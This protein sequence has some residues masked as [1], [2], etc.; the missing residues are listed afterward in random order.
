MFGRKRK[1]SDDQN[2]SM[3]RSNHT[4]LRKES[5]FTDD[6]IDVSSTAEMMSVLREN[7]Y[8][9]VHAISNGNNT[10]LFVGEKHITIPN[11]REMLATYS[12]QQ[13]CKAVETVVGSP[14]DQ[15]NRSEN[16]RGQR[17]SYNPRNLTEP[18]K[19]NKTRKQRYLKADASTF[20]L[21]YDPNNMTN[22]PRK[23]TR[24]QRLY[25]Q[26]QEERQQNPAVTRLFFR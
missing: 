25:K 3:S 2:P 17:L 19:A 16:V 23:M 1:R 20:Y 18:P 21:S 7:G 24:K 13:F 22:T 26:Q 5:A 9:N 10:K 11:K 4:K 14:D 6:P 15:E 12:P 8:K